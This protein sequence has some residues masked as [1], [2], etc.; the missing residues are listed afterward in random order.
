MRQQRLSKC[1]PSEQ[2]KGDKLNKF[3]HQNTF[4]SQPDNSSSVNCPGESPDIS[5]L[6]RMNTGQSEMFPGGPISNRN[7]MRY[8]SE[9]E[10]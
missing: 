1:G 4:E 10:R 8:E 3:L 9:Y 2:S 6:H 7:S 5:N